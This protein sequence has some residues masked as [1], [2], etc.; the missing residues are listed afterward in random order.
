M[1]P[2]MI[3]VKLGLSDVIQL[4]NETLRSHGIPVPTGIDVPDDKDPTGLMKEVNLHLSPTR[5]TIPIQYILSPNERKY[6]V[7][8][9]PFGGTKIAPLIWQNVVKKIFD[10]SGIKTEMMETTHM[11]HAGDIAHNLDL[12]IYNG[13]VAISG[14]GLFHGI[15][16]IKF[17]VHFRNCK[18]T[19]VTQR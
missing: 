15:L 9:N 7:L 10:M 6:L 13:I 12:N 11:G 19:R 2:Y 18:W 16:K 14:D 5:N 3:A 4:F 8:I 17:L 1:S